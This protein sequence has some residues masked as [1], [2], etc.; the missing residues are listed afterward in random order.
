[1]NYL[2]TMNFVSNLFVDTR[3]STRMSSRP[4][5][6]TGLFVLAK[7]IDDAVIARNQQAVINDCR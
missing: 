1:M 2:K 3:E 7:T 6:L 4:F 5:R